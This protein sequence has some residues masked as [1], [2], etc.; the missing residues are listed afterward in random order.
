[1]PGFGNPESKAAAA[2]Q[3]QYVKMP[4]GIAE[5]ILNRPEKRNALSVPM[6]DRITALIHAAERDV[7]VSVLIF[8]GVGKA[9]CSGNEINEDWGQR[10]ASKRRFTLSDAYRYGSDMTYGRQAFSQALGRTSLITIVQLHGFCAAAAYFMIAT[11]CDVVIATEDSKIGAI[12]GR[13]LGPAGAVSHIHLNRILGTKAARRLGYTAEPMSGREALELGLVSECLADEEALRAAVLRRAGELAKR[14]TV[15]LKYLKA[16]ICAAESLL[17][18]SMPAMSGLL[19]SHFFKSEPDELDFW[20]A[21]KSGG[22]A[23]AL[24]EDK[25]RKAALRGDGE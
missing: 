5:I 23:T 6:R 14:S 10:D 24:A 20:K 2:E 3:V 15:E 19:F 25:A 9:F 8:R 22:V 13:F 17:G 21:V 18:V 16:R 12:E 11:R 4:G 1:M 7:E